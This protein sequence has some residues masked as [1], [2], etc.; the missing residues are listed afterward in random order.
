MPEVGDENPDNEYLTNPTNSSSGSNHRRTK[1]ESLDGVYKYYTTAVLTT[2]TLGI[3]VLA[4]ERGFLT[5]R[6]KDRSIWLIGAVNGI[7]IAGKRILRSLI[8]LFSAAIMGAVAYLTMIPNLRGLRHTT[9]KQAKRWVFYSLIGLLASNV[10]AALN[11]TS[12]EKAFKYDSEDKGSFDSATAHYM[13]I[14][15]FL[16]SILAMNVLYLWVILLPFVETQNNPQAPEGESKWSRLRFIV[17]ENPEALRRIGRQNETLRT[18]EMEGK[19]TQNCCSRYTSKGFAVVIDVFAETTLRA[20]QIVVNFCQESV[21]K[22]F[23]RLACMGSM[24]RGTV[25]TNRRFSDS[26]LSIGNW[27]RN[28][29]GIVLLWKVFGGAFGLIS[30]LLSAS[31]RSM[32]KWAKKGGATPEGV[33]YKRMFLGLLNF[34]ESFVEQI[35]CIR[36]AMQDFGR[37]IWDNVKEEEDFQQSSWVKAAVITSLIMLIYFGL[38]LVVHFQGFYTEIY[39]PSRDCLLSNPE[40]TDFFIRS[41]SFD[42]DHH[43]RGTETLPDNFEFVTDTLEI[44]GSTD[45]LVPLENCGDRRI[46]RSILDTAKLFEEQAANATNGTS[47]SSD[48][49]SSTLGNIA[50]ILDVMLQNLA[51]ASWLGFAAGLLIG[52]YSLLSIFAQY[53]RVSYAIRTGEFKK[54]PKDLKTMATADVPEDMELPEHEKWDR[55][56]S[57]YPLSLAVF[58]FGIMVSTAVVQLVVFG[59]LVAGILSLIVSLFD[60]LVYEIMKPFLSFG[61]AFLVTWLLNGFLATAVIGEA[62]LLDRHTL[63]HEM[64]FILFLLVYTAVHLVLGVFLAIVRIVVLLISTFSKISRLDRNLFITWRKR[65]LG[66]KSFV[67]MVFLH[68][69][70]QTIKRQ[71]SNAELWMNVLAQLRQRRAGPNGPNDGSHFQ[72]VDLNGDTRALAN[73]EAGEIDSPAHRTSPSGNEPISVDE[74]SGENRSGSLN[75]AS[76]KK[77]A[78]GKELP[79]AAVDPSA[80]GKTTSNG[81][82]FPEII[83]PGVESVTV[84]IDESGSIPK[85][86]IQDQDPAGTSAAE[87]VMTEVNL[88]EEKSDIQR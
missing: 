38:N 83:H 12:A 43:N 39:M 31:W 46:P 17:R 41:F 23:G 33:W 47:P 76:L 53:K 56:L 60:A 40:F 4:F 10:L 59:S 11:V 68:H 18:R 48:F 14:V 70:F 77:Q 71:D 85:E 35:K 21:P 28:S 86:T 19:K 13:L 61:I 51:W 29:L 79:E 26:L 8:L 81:D 20:T 2:M 74:S 72:V 44:V 52:V 16:V 25:D 27:I 24:Y 88:D 80:S 15:S 67:S 45:E 82:R 7:D 6:K 64:L 30:K 87:S 50:Y 58:F 57:A 62:W 22:A 9:E 73:F 63:V 3:T 66:H 37:Q 75:Q 69:A 42:L 54:L 78:T 1:I 36:P 84:S 55:L 49:T 65:D 32:K 34:F 5:G